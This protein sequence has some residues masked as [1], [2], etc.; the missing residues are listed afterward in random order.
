MTEI[1]PHTGAESNKTDW[2]WTWPNGAQLQLRYLES[3]ED[4]ARYMGK[5]VSWQAFDEAGNWASPAQIDRLFATLRSA[6]GIK[7]V[8]RL[9]GNPGGPGTCVPF[10]DVLTPSG[11]TPIKD[12][13]VGDAVYTVAADGH[14]QRG[15]VGQVHREWFEG[16][17]YS[18]SARGL[19]MVCTPNHRVA[20]TGGVKKDRNRLFSLVPISD[21]PGQAT[22]LR[23][24][25]W[26]GKHPGPFSPPNVRKRAKGKQP[27]TLPSREFFSLLGWYLSE[28]SSAPQRSTFAIHQKKPQH[29]KTIRALLDKCGFRY[30]VSETSF[31]IDDLNWST[32]FA[33]LG[34]QP[35]RRIPDWAKQV[36]QEHLRLMFSAMM[37]GDGHFESEDGGTYYSSSPG[38][39]DDFAEIALKLGYI[40]YQRS[41]VREAFWHHENSVSFKRVK[42]GGTELLTGNHVYDVSTETKR[43]SDIVREPFEGW[44]YCIGVE[45]TETFLIRQGGS[46]WVSGNSWL[47]E[48]YVDPSPPYVPFW[49]APN[50]AYPDLKIESVYIPARLEHNKLLLQNDP[51]YEARLAGI[52]DPELYKAW[53]YGDWNVLSGRY[54]GSFSPTRNVIEPISMSA[55]WP[56]WIGI[57]WGYAHDASV[58]WGCYDGTTLYVYREYTV[59]EA[60]PVEL[61]RRIFELTSKHE[62]IERVFLSP[63]AFARKS[64]PR[65]IADEI[66][67]ELPWPVVPADNDRI[68]GWS[69]MQTML[70]FGTL[71]IFDNCARLT[72]WL[73]LA[74]R[75]PKRPEDVLKTEG[76]DVGDSCRYL[77]KSTQIEPHIPAD[78]VMEQKIKPFLDKE[79]YMGAFIQR[80]RMKDELEKNKKPLKLKGRR[81]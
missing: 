7:C 26:S 30:R 80:M 8:R 59:N 35:V 48:R 62:R 43:R 12:M 9:T 25:K 41:R 29:V 77:I 65:T 45:G 37:D 5:N 67:S 20:K 64:S 15:H 69:L 40:V 56:K 58:H 32:Y 16:N 49:W 21:L 31:S 74:Q 47:K 23:S 14:L 19:R 81:R 78:I 36:D 22:I 66:R 17:L 63:D 73:G 38:L 61:A 1:Y 28:G 44:V 39:A 60:T 6:H 71:K 10:G 11:W 33:S 13:K 70:R 18:V 4:A 79:D 27:Q 53:R 51:G 57:D 24:V 72:K 76:D 52:G 34:L 42:S 68:G 55:W 50:P 75:D 46:V 2:T 3:D 54:F